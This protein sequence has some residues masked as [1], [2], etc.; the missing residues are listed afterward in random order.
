MSSG[1]SSAA[2][3]R[4]LTVVGVAGGVGTMQS[5]NPQSVSGNCRVAGR[6]CT[7]VARR[8]PCCLPSFVPTRQVRNTSARLL[9]RPRH[10]QEKCLG[11]VRRY[12]HGVSHCTDSSYAGLRG[13]TARREHFILFKI[14]YVEGCIVLII[15]V[16]HIVS[17]ITLQLQGPPSPVRVRSS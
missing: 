7:A 8:Q 14:H 3:K 15:A 13:T 10:P 12:G 11:N 9:H 2:S 5:Q 17:T 6:N 4:I 16:P 1:T